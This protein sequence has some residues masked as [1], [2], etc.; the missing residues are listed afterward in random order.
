[1]SLPLSA[2]GGNMF[3][4]QRDERTILYFVGELREEGEEHG[5]P[6]RS[7]RRVGAQ[8]KATARLFWRVGGCVPGAEGG[9]GRGGDRSARPE[10]HGDTAPSP[11]GCFKYSK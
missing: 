7:E 1:M 8:P 3:E 4:T 6:R 11:A 9:L 2:G 5:S 10:W